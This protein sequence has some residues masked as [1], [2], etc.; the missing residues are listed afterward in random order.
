MLRAQ[1]NNGSI[2]VLI[3]NGYELTEL[4]DVDINTGSL[5]NNDLLAYDSASTQWVNRTVTGVGALTT[6]SFNAYTSSTDSRLTNIETAT[7]SLFTSASLTLVTASVNLNTITFTKGDSTTFALTVD[8]GSGGGGGG[9]AFPYTGSAE[10]TGS[11]IVTGSARGNVV[12]LTVASSTAS[13]DFGAANYF[14]LTLPTS[15]TTHFT[16]TN[17]R[18]G[19]TATLILTTGTGG[20]G[21][22]ASFSPSFLQ[23][24]GSSYQPTS[25]SARRDILSFV[26]FDTASVYVVSSKNMI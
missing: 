16:A 19:T 6:S 23:P 18:P 24:Q 21:A 8:T 13:I 7:S 26:S 9:A 25:G 2:Y 20:T 10:I 11:L 5:A 4:H 22:T 3:Q 12:A 17:I 14:T 1:Q 15:S